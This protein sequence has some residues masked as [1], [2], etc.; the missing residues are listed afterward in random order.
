MKVLYISEGISIIYP[1]QLKSSSQYLIKKQP[2]QVHYMKRCSIKK[3]FWEISQN[4]QEST[5]SRVSFLMKWLRLV[6]L[7]K[8][9][10]QSRCFPVNFARSL[11]TPCFFCEFCEI[12]KNNLFAENVWVIASDNKLVDKTFVLLR[13]VLSYQQCISLIKIS[14][15]KL[16]T[17]GTQLLP[18][19]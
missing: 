9:R 5:C 12:F 7:L 13:S 3:M 15:I 6:T 19:N 1:C 8:K 17:L 11:R 16:Q 4:S 10:L 2:Q 18:E 14:K